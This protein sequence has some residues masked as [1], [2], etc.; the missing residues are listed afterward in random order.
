MSGDL[1]TAFIGRVTIRTRADCIRWSS[2]SAF[3]MKSIAHSPC[4]AIV[5]G[6]AKRQCNEHPKLGK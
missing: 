1:L 6:M 4:L 3:V 2:A 5:G